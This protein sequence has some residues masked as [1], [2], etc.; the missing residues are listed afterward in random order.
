MSRYISLIT[1]VFC[2]NACSEEPVA[3]A[4][5]SPP[6]VVETINSQFTPSA[7]KENQNTDS[8]EVRHTEDTEVRQFD[9]S[10]LSDNPDDSYDR[11]NLLPDLFASGEKDKGASISGGILRDGENPD[12]MQSV[13]GA[14]ISIEIKTG[15]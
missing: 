8:P 6:E 13:E 4:I 2:L 3:P 15:K 12:L 5:D 7:E 10:D 11:E 9:M 1:F 14:E